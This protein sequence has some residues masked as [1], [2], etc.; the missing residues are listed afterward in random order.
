MFGLGTIINTATVIAGGIIG[1]LIGGFL[2]PRFQHI[3]LSAIGLI[4]MFMGIGGSVAKMLVSDGAGS[5]DTRGTLMSVF[6]LVLGGVVG[7]IIDLD[8]LSEKFGSWLKVKTKSTRDSRFVDG[9]VSAS[10]TV[11]IGAM[12]VMGSLMD[13]LTG[14]FSILLTKA[15]IDF[16]TVLVMATSMGKGCIFSAIPVFVFQGT[17]TVLAKLIAPVMNDQAMVNL[18][19]VGNMLIFCV[20]FNMIFTGTKRIKVA[21]LL[22]AIIFAVGAAYIP[23]LN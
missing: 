7:E 13:G 5:F 17:I 12:A 11:C 16:I 6:A 20:G 8:R 2:R 18:S 23:F 1:S 14:D 4:V 15:I 19:I 22:P 9:F 10:L 21:N 3:V